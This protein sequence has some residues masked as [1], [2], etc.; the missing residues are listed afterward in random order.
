MLENYTHKFKW[1]GKDI[2]VPNEECVRKGE[3]LLS[4]GEAIALPDYFFHYRSGGHVA[5]LHAHLKNTFFFRIDLKNFFYTV[6]RN[7][8]KA[9]LIAF[10]F[11]RARTYSKWSVVRNPYGDVPRYVLPIGFVQSPLLASLVLM[12]SAVAGAIENAQAKG[13]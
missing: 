13:V 4:W 3:V 2:Y 12:R 5:A 7:R 9:A 1:R 6:G 11:N 10:G 8:V